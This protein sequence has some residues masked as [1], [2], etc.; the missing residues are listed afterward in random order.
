MR[1]QGSGV[2][3]VPSRETIQTTLDFEINRTPF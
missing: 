2:C 3:S 1:A